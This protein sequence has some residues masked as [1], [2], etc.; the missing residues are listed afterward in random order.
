MHAFI[1]D[2]RLGILT[3]PLVALVITLPYMAYQYRRFGSISFWKTLVVY[4]FVFYC[5][6]ACY[7]IALPLP[8]DRTAFIPNREPQL[9]PA[10][11]IDQIKAV[12]A[13]TSFS[14]GD[15]STWAPTLKSPVVYEALF[16]VL[17]T[18]P[19]GVYL[20]YLFNC[21][22]WQAF[23][24]GLATTCLFEF[25]QLTGLFGLYAHPYRLFDV[26]DIILNTA[27]CM[28]GFWLA[29]P[30]T[31][32]LPS[33]D[34]IN[35]ASRARG[36]A[37]VS[38]TRR[39]FACL[40]DLIVSSILFLVLWLIARPTDLQIAKSL[41]LDPSKAQ[42]KGLLSHFWLELQADPVSALLVLFLCAVIV[43]MLLPIITGGRTP[44]QALVGI[45]I[46]N[47]ETGARPAWYAY[48]VRYGTLAL[49]VSAPLWMGALAPVDIEGMSGATM[50]EMLVVVYGVWIVTLIIRAVASMMGKPVVMLNEVLSNTRLVPAHAPHSNQEPRI[51]YESQELSEPRYDAPYSGNPYQDTYQAPGQTVRMPHLD[52]RYQ[53]SHNARRR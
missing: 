34:S 36:L 15:R 40:V 14:L 18:L 43:F 13:S 27:G 11:L 31:A 30:A 1:S 22:W 5:L 35:D 41:A 47:A 52:Q 6:C 26:D 17:L 49:F 23:C 51:P 21:K 42:A 2:I 48:L 4:S 7:L 46:V 32:V 24:I 45:R 19:L 29:I 3:F 25:S 20:R 39:M 9:D 50:I 38:V 28:I 16:N 37:R 44:G 53:R 12:M 33:M 10:N 8:A